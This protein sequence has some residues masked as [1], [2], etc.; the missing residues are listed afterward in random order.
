MNPHFILSIATITLLTSFSIEGKSAALPPLAEPV[1]N[2]AVAKVVVDNQPYFIS[3]MGLG[4]KKTYKD[5]HDKVY[6]LKL[7]ANQWQQKTSVPA[8]LALKGRL[9]STAVGIGADAYVFGGYTVSSDHAEISSPDVYKYSVESDSYTKLASMPV[10]VDDSVALSY[11]NRYIYLVSGWHNDGNVNLTQVYDTQTNR[12]Q[13]ASPFLGEA[14]FGQA[15]AI[16]NNVMVVC[17]GVKTVANPDKRRSFAEVAQCLKGTIDP[18]NPLKIDW[19][20]ISHPSVNQKDAHYRM[21]AT[22]YNGDI[23]MMAG[24]NNPYNYNG[25]GYDGRPAPASAHV[26]R[27][28][29]KTNQWQTLPKANAA[30]MDHRGLLEHNGVLHRIGGMNEQQQVIADVHPYIIKN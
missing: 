2:N 17:D 18:N 19:R 3:F 10:P 8:T 5:V 29:I 27:F 11:Q 13:Q 28:D 21:A 9:A 6:V 16:S 4:P 15:G 24:S 22:S 7:G 26:W 12:W 1:A 23:Y 14:V 25:M 20:T 30:T